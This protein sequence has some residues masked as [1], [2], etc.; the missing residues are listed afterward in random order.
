VSTFNSLAVAGDIPQGSS[1][2]FVAFDE[3]TTTHQ[4]IPPEDVHAGFY[5]K[6][7]ALQGGRSAF[8]T[9]RACCGQLTHHYPM[10]V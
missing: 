3:H 5:H 2:T 9:R 4:P 8:Y 6:L 10:G 1:L 7:Y